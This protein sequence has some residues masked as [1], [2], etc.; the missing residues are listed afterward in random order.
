MQNTTMQ[1]GGVTSYD[2]VKGNLEVT[3]GKVGLMIED[4]RGIGK[5]RIISGEEGWKKRCG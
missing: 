5:D 3:L 1:N 2:H 4:P